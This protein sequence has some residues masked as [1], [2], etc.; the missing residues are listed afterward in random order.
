MEKFKQF[1]DRFSFPSKE[2]RKARYMIDMFGTCPARERETL[3]SIIR[4]K[5]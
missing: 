1:V 5:L 4:K 2:A 3:R